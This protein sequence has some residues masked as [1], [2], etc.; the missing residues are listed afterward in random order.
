M[1]MRKTIYKIL[2]L[3]LVFVWTGGSNLSAQTS[4]HLWGDKPATWRM[5]FTQL[6]IRPANPS[7]NTGIAVIICPGG[8]YCYL[9]MKTEGHL[10]AKWLHEQGINAF[11]LRYRIG[12]WG[13]HHPAMIQD[14]Q[15]AI[16]WV[17]EHAAEYHVDPHKIGVMGFS[18]G[19]HLAGTAAIYYDRNFMEPLHIQPRCSLRPDF[20]A[21]IYPVVTMEDSLA[22]YKSQCNLLG[23]FPTEAVKREFSLEEQVHE[24]MPPIF[25]VACK[26]DKTVKCRNSINLHRVMEQKGL[27]CTFFLY[28]R[29]GH[30]FGANDD[31]AGSIA[32]HWKDEFIKW[33]KNL[34]K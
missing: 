29:G 10:V 18:A 13:N 15:R 8:S 16:Q 26:D 9:G 12:L 6:H 25:L 32:R 22:H 3:L 7:M 19:G 11:I 1:S 33:I 4:I 28:D 31:K 21:M 23:D 17:R 24:G 20:A 34:Y 27:P 30:G 2:F 5:R 14:M